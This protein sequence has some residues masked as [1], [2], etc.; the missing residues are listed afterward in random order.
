MDYKIERAFVDAIGVIFEG[1]FL[2]VELGFEGFWK[3][4]ERLLLELM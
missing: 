1:F 4:G 2:F 3:L